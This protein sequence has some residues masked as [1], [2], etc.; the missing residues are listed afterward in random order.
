MREWKMKRIYA[1]FCLTFFSS[2]LTAQNYTER[3]KAAMYWS[4]GE[5]K[6]VMQEITDLYSGTVAAYHFYKAGQIEV[7]NH[8]LINIDRYDRIFYE[9]YLDLFKFAS[10][11]DDL[12][13]SARPNEPWNEKQLTAFYYFLSDYDAFIS[14]LKT[15]YLDKEDAGEMIFGIFPKTQKLLDSNPEKKTLTDNLF[16]KISEMELTDFPDKN[17]ETWTFP[18]RIKTPPPAR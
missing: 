3:D 1:V 10:Y 17:E 11:F 14:K 7:K 2:L 15:I 8:L 18:K 16:R 6:K 12:E 13:N 4:A 5:C 9:F